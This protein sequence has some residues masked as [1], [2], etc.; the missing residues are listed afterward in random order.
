ML[1]LLALG[2]LL[3][4]ASPASEAE[5]VARW[6]DLAREIMLTAGVSDAEKHASG[7]EALGYL[8]RAQRISARPLLTER[9]D[10][11]YLAG[12]DRTALG[13]A[14]DVDDLTGAEA[15]RFRKRMEYLEHMEAEGTLRDRACPRSPVR[16]GNYLVEAGEQCDDG[17][18]VDGDGCSASCTIE[19]GPGRLLV[20]TTSPGIRV[21]VDGAAAGETPVSV[22]L[23]A[24]RHIVEVDDPCVTAKPVAVDVA[25]EQVSTVQLEVEPRLAVAL[26]RG[27][28]ANGKD[29]E[30][31]LFTGGREVGP[32]PSRYNLPVCG[33]HLK[34][35]FADGK[36]VE[37]NVTL[38]EGQTEVALR[39]PRD[40]MAPYAAAYGIPWGLTIAGVAG[41][42]TLIALPFSPLL[43]A[44][45][46]SGLGE[47]PMAWLGAVAGY[48]VYGVGLALAVGAVVAG[49][50]VG[51]GG[52]GL[53]AGAGVAF[54]TVYVVEP[55][56]AAWASTLGAQ[57]TESDSE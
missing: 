52:V 1:T 22:D 7:C 45:W 57:G 43:Q 41:G 21:L 4:T 46:I 8:E 47:Y 51:A 14:R 10:A 5:K 15:A 25:D 38:A 56:V 31:T 20:R 12:L 49:T 29:A 9:F 27:E 23:P 13:L 3:P 53:L 24:G 32:V 16:C 30:G 39:A 28:L 6:L 37:R 33:V 11:A 18:L 55:W 40:P 17:N 54:T 35:V 34:V 42:I 26:V 48:A 2:V 19:R 44:W 50:A 36:S